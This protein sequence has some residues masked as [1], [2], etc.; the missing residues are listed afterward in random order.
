MSGFCGFANVDHG[1]VLTH[2]GAQDWTTHVIH[3][4][5][6]RKYEIWNGTTGFILQ[7]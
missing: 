1:V 2:H 6:E 5:I 7:K 4:T 3:T